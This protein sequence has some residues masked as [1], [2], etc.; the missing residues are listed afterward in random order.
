MNLILWLGVGAKSCH[1]SEQ[2]IDVCILL[3]DL[4][5]RKIQNINSRARARARVCVCVCV[6]QQAYCIDSM[7]TYCTNYI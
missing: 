5:S 2:L 6:W 1:D 3:L 4:S 7:Y